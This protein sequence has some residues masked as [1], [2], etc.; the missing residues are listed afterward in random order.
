MAD[1]PWGPVGCL[2]CWESYM[3]LARVAL[4]QKGVTIYI[5]ANTNDN[6]E[7][8]DTIKHIAIEGHCWFINADLYF[9]RKCIRTISTA[10]MKLLSFR[11][12]S[13]AAA[14]VSWIRADIMRPILCGQREY[15]L[16]RS[17][18]G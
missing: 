3:P 15:N 1:T 12:Q 4:Y 17:R 7:W 13:A 10:R 8:Q 14:A 11:K 5:S 9:T 18:Y 16:L 2:I 6:P